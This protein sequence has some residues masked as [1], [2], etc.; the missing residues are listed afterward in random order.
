MKTLIACFFFTVATFWAQAQTTP[1]ITDVTAQQRYPWNGKVDIS[2]TVSGIE[3]IEAVKKEYGLLALNLK[4]SAADQESGTTNVAMSVSGDMTLTNGT[5]HIVWDMDAD[6]LS[7][8]STAVVFTVSCETT[9]ATYCVIDLSEGAEASSYPVT[10]LAEPPLGGFNISEYKTTKL[11]LRRIEPGTFMMCGQ[12]HTTLTKPYYMGIF[13]VTQKQYKLVKG[14]HS[15]YG[16]GD[17]RPA[18][19]L[20]YNMI[21]GSS[22]GAEWPSSSAVDASTIIGMLRVRTGLNFD[23]PTE[24]QWEYACRAGTSSDYNNGGN[25]ESDLQ[26]LGRYKG[27]SP[28]SSH[29]IVGSYQPNAW[30]LYDMHGNII[31]WCLDWFGDLSSPLIDPNGP[32]SGE[33]RV[34]RGGSSRYPALECTS[35]SRFSYK[36]SDGYYQLPCGFRLARTV[37]HSD[38]ATLCLS[39]SSLSSIDLTQELRTAK[40]SEFIRY[41]TSWF[42]NATDAQASVTVNGSEIASIAGSGAI[43][44]TPTKNGIYTLTHRVL[45]NG[46]Q[47]GETLTASF[48]MSHGPRAPIFSPI[49]GVVDNWP[50]GIIITCAT[51]GAVIHYTTDGS[52]P[53]AESPRYGRFRI[54][55]RTTVKAV[56]VKDGLVGDV[57]VAE[58]AAGQCADPV[59]TPEDGTAFEHAGQEVSIAWQ[60]A[61]GILRYTTDGN[62]PTADSPVYSG[63]FTIDNSTIVKAK[64]F[65]DQYFDSAIVTANLTRVWTNVAT[66]MIAAA[67]SFTG[68]KTEVGMT[69]ATEGATIRYTTDGTEPGASTTIYT[70]PF[71]VTDSCTIKAYA[72]C[73][74]Y[75]GSA[76]A[77]RTITKIWGVGDTLGAP[78]HT[79]TTG[80]NLPFVRVTDNTAPLGESMKSGAITDSQ[81]STLSTTVMGPGT[82]SFQWK[83]SCEDSDGYYDWDHAEFWVDGTRI[84]QLDGETT[85]QT[86]TQAISGSGSHTLLWKYVKDDMSSEGGDCC[87]VADYHWASAYTAT[88]TTEVPVPYAWLRGYYPHT[89][90]EYDAYESAA[91]DTA[92][93]GVNKMWEC[94]VAGLNPTNVTDVFRAV[95]SMENGKP[96]IGWTPDL[97]EGGTKQERVYIVEGRPSLTEGDW[98]ELRIE[99]GELR[100][101]DCRF[102]R[103]KVTLP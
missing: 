97:N 102:F 2:Y 65:G 17:T 37:T 26:T 73:Y 71:Y 9:P 59:I 89:A 14:S 74:D 34:M 31:E 77:S 80:G 56:A 36:P 15:A 95:I 90:D 94:Y 3:D 45:A 46:I 78:D 82:I 69:C 100:I 54:N 91:K 27:N 32:P 24:A 75:L 20:S 88:Q 64:A 42:G 92:A 23:L 43:V 60:G 83:T 79:F 101:G 84:A 85:W 50:Q 63:S 18:D 61:D 58:Y 5:H 40:H 30:G 39:D 19:Q 62:D 16:Q 13:E 81:Q 38:S 12:Y 55:G 28:Y 93:N 51:E 76:I 52:E 11:V 4:V 67:S 41:S 44:W 103:V 6:G 53:T 96:V 99:N 7:I 57:A 48:K 1:T 98:E 86:V 68:S 35:S 29:T 21:R 72:T 33:K 25:D 47:V 66:P 22:S 70:G 8:V 10:Y 87:W 49:G